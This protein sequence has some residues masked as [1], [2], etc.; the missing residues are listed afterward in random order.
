M[1]QVMELVLCRPERVV[2]FANVEST[3]HDFFD[4][5]MATNWKRTKV[6]IESFLQ[7]H[8][9]QP[10]NAILNSIVHHNLSWKIM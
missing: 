5:L 10:L 6:D 1:F 3:E 8:E 7:L 2:L 9:G 4:I